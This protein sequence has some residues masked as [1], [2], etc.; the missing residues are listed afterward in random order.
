MTKAIAWSLC[1]LHIHVFCT[2]SCW[3]FAF[4][5]ITFF[6][7]G[8][9]KGRCLPWG[10]EWIYPLFPALSLWLRAVLAEPQL[11]MPFVTPDLPSGAG[12]CQERV[13]RPGRSAQEWKA[14]WRRLESTVF[15]P[16]VQLSSLQPRPHFTSEDKGWKERREAGKLPS[17]TIINLWRGAVLSLWG[18]SS[19]LSPVWW[20]G[21][22]LN[23]LPSWN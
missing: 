23:I 22:W 2:Y 7:L 4:L 20:G 14:A 11:K 5:L 10:R 13:G 8:G 3:V 19:P 1:F 18:D 15:A 16:P 12:P 17:L 6:S 9:F 21:D